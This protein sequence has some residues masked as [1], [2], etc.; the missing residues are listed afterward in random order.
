MVQSARDAWG[1]LEPG[2]DIV[3]ALLEYA[4]ALG[5]GEI[6]LRDL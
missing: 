2:L 6:A 1:V 5:V 3:R 4:A